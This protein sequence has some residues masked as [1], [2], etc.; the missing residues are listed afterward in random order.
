MLQI[1]TSL[2]VIQSIFYAIKVIKTYFHGP[3]I[4]LTLPDFH[5]TYMLNYEAARF[6]SDNEFPHQK[7]M[8]QFSHISRLPPGI[9]YFDL[10]FS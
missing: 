5:L 8:I 9:S 3:L 6:F 2:L 7:P 1:N 4:L 10:T